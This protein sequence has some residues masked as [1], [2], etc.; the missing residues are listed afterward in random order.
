MERALRLV[1]NS[2]LS[3]QV[4]SPSDIARGLWPLAAGKRVAAHTSRVTVVRTTLVVEV[5]DA[6]WQKQLYTLRA[7]VLHNIR[8]LMGAGV[9]EDLEFRIAVPK[10]EPQRADTRQS[11]PEP[12]AP[13][14]DEADAI[15]DPVLRRI[16]RR[17]RKNAIA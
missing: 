13:S 15:E 16:Y 6:V 3:R 11:I 5:E 14:G 10:R 8:K 2:K 12:V 17:S 9:I 1:T 7:Q 4:L